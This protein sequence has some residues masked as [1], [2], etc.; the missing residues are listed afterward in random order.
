VDM[1][2]SGK[3]VGGHAHVIKSHHNVRSPLVEEKR[4]QGRLVEPLAALYKDEVRK[5]GAVLGVDEEVLH[6][7]PFPGPGLAVRIL[8]EVDKEKC[9]LL[10]EA[11]AIY[12]SELK[13]RG[14]YRRIWQA[15][16]VLL[17]VRS[18]G[19]T[20]DA[21]RFSSV[22][23]LRAITSTDGMTADVFPFPMEDLLEISSLITNSLHD[24]SRVV[25]DVSSKPPATIEWE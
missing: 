25:Y 4:R 17:P 15:F 2:E 16:C 19:V 24:I 3:G 11:D 18:V 10:R 6:R 12:M 14:L 21:R 9:E 22:L 20:G 5:L 13:R 23:A 1:I 8:G 7:H